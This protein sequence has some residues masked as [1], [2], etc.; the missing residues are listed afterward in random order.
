MTVASGI[1]GAQVLFCVLVLLSVVGI[2]EAQGS[3]DPLAE[4]GL[5]DS[6]KRDSAAYG[7]NASAFPSSAST[8]KQTKEQDCRD[9]DVLVLLDRSYSME[10]YPRGGTSRYTKA[11]G[12][13]RQLEEDAGDSSLRV[14]PF[15]S[16]ETPK[17]CVAGDVASFSAA[18]GWDAPRKGAV[19]PLLHV[20][21]RAVDEIG[22]ATGTTRLV[23]ITDGYQH[24]GD[25]RELGKKE[26]AD[27][28]EQEFS[29]NP[30]AKE[31]LVGEP[32]V[33]F[34]GRNK[35][36]KEKLEFVLKEVFKA[37]SCPEPLISKQPRGSTVPG[38]AKV[39]G[40][41]VPRTK[42]PGPQVPGPTNKPVLPKPQVPS[43]TSP[44]GRTRPPSLEFL[45]VVAVGSRKHWDCS[46]VLVRP[47]AGT[48]AIG[49]SFVLTAKHCL[50]ATHILA[51]TNDVR[52]SL[53]IAIVESILHPN[54]KTD[55]ALLQ[56]AKRLPNSTHRRRVPGDGGGPS[57]AFRIVGFGADSADGRFG[58]GDIHIRDLPSNG[59]GCTV[60]SARA[61]GCVPGA[62]MVVRGN[63]GH[64]SCRGDS[65]GPIYERFGCGFRLVGITSRAI[66]SS[67][68]ACGDGGIYTRVDAFAH[69][70]QK[71]MEKS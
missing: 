30:D 56:L 71:A 6:D 49:A 19:T 35:G 53:P 31:K 7:L 15:P 66:P 1:R 26:L 58:A 17:E 24:C 69:W 70:I 21:Q 34:L 44:F 46:G 55:L 33:I 29:G 4:C 12:Y 47:S 27:I 62:E 22:K 11:M 68:R 32:N 37:P 40:P 10:F 16:V 14:I 48:T 50:P 25:A 2:A 5:L 42:V 3:F 67:R 36:Q 8:G 54:P 9:A 13:L 41:K 28:L 23:I 51:G 18:T 43:I 63:A 39:P 52:S 45:D 64:D 38:S 61:L 59:W 65:G 20:L 57:G 60:K